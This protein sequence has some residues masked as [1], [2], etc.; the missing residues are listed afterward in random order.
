MVFASSLLSIFG[1]F[2]PLLDIGDPQLGNGVTVIAVK[3]LDGSTMHLNEDLIERVENASGGQSAIFLRYGGH[4][5][6]A[7]D[8]ATVVELVRAERA[9]L[10]S[11]VFEHMDDV[12]DEP[13]PQEMTGHVTPLSQVRSL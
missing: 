8:P 6:V 10:L 2:G 9:A 3:K 13:D 1:G 5:I 12:T 7:N 11:R 4:I